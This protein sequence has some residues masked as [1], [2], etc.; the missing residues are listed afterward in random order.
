[1]RQISCSHECL[2]LRKR[3]RRATMREHRLE[4][5]APLTKVAANMPEL[6]QRSCE[7]QPRIIFP[8]FARFQRGP[9]IIVLFLQPVEPHRLI[10]ASQ[11]RFYGFYETQIPIHMP[12]A[13]ALKLGGFVEPVPTVPANR[14][15][16]TVP[17]LLF[18]RVHDDKGL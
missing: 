3:R 6:P 13:H 4:P 2:R 5:P 15:Q 9:E 17:S 10:R 11:L 16:Q 8:C 7:A 18:L 1:M 14:L 12:D